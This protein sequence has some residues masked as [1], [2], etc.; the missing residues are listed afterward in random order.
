MDYNHLIYQ[1]LSSAIKVYNHLGGGRRES[2][3]R[4]AIANELYIRGVSCRVEPK[5][6]IYYGEEV[7]GTG[8]PDIVVEDKIILELK[9]SV[10]KINDGHIAQLDAYM[11][12][13]EYVEGLVI[14]FNSNRIEHVSIRR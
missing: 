13:L 12:D 1:S 9:V 14:L 7:V 11:R 5:Y 4:D 10:A 8:I 6:H 2:A 3:Y